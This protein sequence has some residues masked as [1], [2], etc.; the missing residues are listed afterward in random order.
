MKAQ[1]SWDIGR[2]PT[3]VCVRTKRPTHKQNTS[4][5]DERQLF[6]TKYEIPTVDLGQ[7]ELML[8]R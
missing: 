7:Q 4:N 2:S 1:E 6:I 8:R 3:I 5:D